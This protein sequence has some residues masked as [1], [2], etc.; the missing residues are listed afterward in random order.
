MTKEPMIIEGNISVDQLQADVHVTLL[1]GSITTY[2][3]E[4]YE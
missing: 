3:I 1:L 2:G 4:A